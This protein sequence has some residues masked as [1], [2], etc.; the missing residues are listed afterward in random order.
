MVSM[1]VNLEKFGSKKVG[2]TRMI[3]WVGFFGTVATIW[4]GDTKMILAKLSVGQRIEDIF[5]R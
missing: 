5:P 1:L 2:Y 4:D 3:H